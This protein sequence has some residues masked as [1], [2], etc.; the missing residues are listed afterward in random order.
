MANRAQA[1][2][3]DMRRAITEFTNKPSKTA[4][5]K[6][7]R[8]NAFWL[9]GAMDSVTANAVWIADYNKS[10]AAG[11]EEQAAI[12]HADQLVT[13]T[14]GSAMPKDVAGVMRGSEAWQAWTILLHVFQLVCS[15]S[16]TRATP[17]LP[18][19]LALCGA[20]LSWPRPIYG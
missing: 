20:G 16:S 10:V 12:D 9:I 18:A 2:D 5:D 7:A 1:I 14:Q 11:M 13:A 19:S 3:R 4:F 8:E 15:T 6:W 17:G